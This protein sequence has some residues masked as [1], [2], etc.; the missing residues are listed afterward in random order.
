[1]SLTIPRF[2]HSS[3]RKGE[4][5]IQ[6][7]ITTH[8][9]IFYL[10]AGYCSRTFFPLLPRGPW[11]GTYIPSVQQQILMRKLLIV[12]DVA[13][14]ARRNIINNNCCTHTH[15]KQQR[16]RRRRRLWH[17]HRELLSSAATKKTKHWLWHHIV[18]HDSNENNNVSNRINN[19]SNNNTRTHQ[20]TKKLSD[21]KHLLTT[22]TVSTDIRSRLARR[23]IVG[24]SILLYTMV[25]SE[26]W[27]A[28]VIF[29]YS[30]KSLISK[31]FIYIIQLKTSKS[32]PIP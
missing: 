2:I 22:I 9:T 13:C 8:W 20:L 25:Y 29:L 31:I 15:Q 14:H 28:S 24:Q 1:M 10:F 27:N 16:C 11:C 21:Q 7:S 32:I 18:S 5:V 23:L 19:N 4:S 26:K 6:H 17:Q 12:D 30:I 3:L